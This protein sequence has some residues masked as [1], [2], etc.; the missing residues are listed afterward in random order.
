MDHG[1]ELQGW[2]IVVEQLSVLR[3]AGVDRLMN[4]SCVQ[5]LALGDDQDKAENSPEGR[6]WRDRLTGPHQISVPA[7]TAFL[8]HAF[9]LYTQCL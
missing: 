7:V 9:Y 5:D 3:V 4:H 2:A 8:V 6:V 1:V